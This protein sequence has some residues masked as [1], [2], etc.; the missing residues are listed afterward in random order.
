[1]SSQVLVFFNAQ[2]IKITGLLTPR[3]LGQLVASNFNCSGIKITLIVYNEVTVNCWYVPHLLT[4]V[5]FGA[6]GLISMA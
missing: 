5:K 6:L 3:K 4:K 2:T 1:M